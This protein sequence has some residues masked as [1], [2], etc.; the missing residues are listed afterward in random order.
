MSK[1]ITALAIFVFAI[2]YN[3]VGQDPI[4]I[5]SLPVTEE[6]V[7]RDTI[8]AVL[9]VSICD[10]CAPVVVNG[11]SVGVYNVY[12]IYEMASFRPKPIYDHRELLWTDKKQIPD[13]IIVWKFHIKK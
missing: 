8:P 13:F 6:P 7:K 9:L 11:Y 4:G 3:L 1:L 10:T 5:S 2:T 12:Y